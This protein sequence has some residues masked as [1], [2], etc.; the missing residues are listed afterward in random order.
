MLNKFG[1]NTI[2]FIWMSVLYYPI[3][4]CS[5]L[6]LNTSKCLNA[7]NRYCLWHYKYWWR[8]AIVN[9]IQHMV[10]T[11]LASYYCLFEYLFL[12]S[13][14]MLS[15][16]YHIVCYWIEWKL[17]S[18]YERQWNMLIVNDRRVE[19]KRTSVEP[20]CMRFLSLKEKKTRKI[21]SR[22]SCVFPTKEFNEI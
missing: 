9:Q 2:D 22:L 13:L 6:T 5:Y 18:A 10:S 14:I 11:L 16:D 8:I 17:W 12:K 1:L 7:S 3:S 4:D 21:L 20:K 19:T 15:F